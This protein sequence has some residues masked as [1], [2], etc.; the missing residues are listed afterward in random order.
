MLFTRLL[1]YHRGQLHVFIRPFLYMLP[2]HI[3]IQYIRSTTW[4]FKTT[5]NWHSVLSFFFRSLLHGAWSVLLTCDSAITTWTGSKGCC[6]HKSHGLIFKT[7]RPRGRPKDTHWSRVH[8]APGR[9]GF[10]FVHWRK[11]S[12]NLLR[13]SVSFLNEEHGCKTK[14]NF[15]PGSP[16]W[17]VRICV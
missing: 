14:P 3:T 9:Q 6:A 4:I 12:T 7:G 15:K 16:R 11:M 1:I 2:L 5:Q 13:V 17:A 8:H 10:V